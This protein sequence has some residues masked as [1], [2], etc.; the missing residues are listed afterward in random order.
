M[1]TAGGNVRTSADRF[2]IM[3][4]RPG[5]DT[6][7][8]GEV[9]IGSPMSLT[10]YFNEGNFKPLYDMVRN[11]T[12]DANTRADRTVQTWGFLKKDL[13]RRPL[14]QLLLQAQ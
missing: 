7:D 10:D 14:Y 5:N 1:S 12:R 3:P 2:C 11:Y 13:C 8:E 6:T 9:R 4:L